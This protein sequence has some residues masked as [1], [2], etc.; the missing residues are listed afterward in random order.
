VQLEPTS[1]GRTQRYDGREAAELRGARVSDPLVSTFCRNE[2]FLSH[3]YTTSLLLREKFGAAGCGA[4]RSRGSRSPELLPH[5]PP[6]P[7]PH[8]CGQYAPFECAPPHRIPAFIFSVTM[9]PRFKR[10]RSVPGADKRGVLGAAPSVGVPE[11]PL[12]GPFLFVEGVTFF[13]RRARRCRR[14]PRTCTSGIFRG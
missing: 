2:L 7:P 14:I 1:P 6:S 3:H 5:R 4:Q 13:R 11:A 10:L 12:V 9:H 8:L